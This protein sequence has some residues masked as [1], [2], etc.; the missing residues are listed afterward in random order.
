MRSN[1]PEMGVA[2]GIARKEREGILDWFS[3]NATSAIPEGLDSVIQS[4]ERAAGGFGNVGC[5]ETMVFLRLGRL[6]FSA[7]LAVSS[8]THWKQRRAQNLYICWEGNRCAARRCRRGSMPCSQNA[9]PACGA[10]GF[11]RASAFPL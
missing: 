8:A 5:L 2:A 11:C 10:L 9:T 4:I 7:R 3:R 6:G 1:A